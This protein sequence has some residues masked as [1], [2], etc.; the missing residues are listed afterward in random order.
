M[1]VKTITYTDFLGQT[2]TEDF[3]FNYSKSDVNRLVMSTKEGLMEFL[4]RITREEDRTK[5]FGFIEEFILKAYGE[6]SPD[7]RQFIKN[8]ELST[9]F[10]QTNAYA[11]LIDELIN[12]GDQAF[13]D[14]IK[15]VIP[16]EETAAMAESSKVTEIPAKTN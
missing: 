16:K 8:E 4:K 7:G 10:K 3:Y 13:S 15:A 9:G 6:I 1:L 5:M 11:E 12:G 14:F 2:R